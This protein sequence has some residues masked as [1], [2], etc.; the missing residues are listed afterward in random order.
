MRAVEDEYWWYAALRRHVADEVA[1]R[2]RGG[3]IL[4]SGCGTG[5][6]LAVLR[7]RFPDAELVGVD[8][9][10]HALELTAARRAGAELHRA[11]VSRLPFGDQSFGCALSI[12]VITAATVDAAA[13]VAELQ[14]VLLPGG[15]LI[16]NVAAFRFLTGAH[17]V[18]VD[19]N[20]RFTRPE[21]VALLQ[22]HEF[23]VDYATYWNASMFP[24]V[25]TV[26]WLSRSQS[27]ARSDFTRLPSVVNSVLREIAVTELRAARF[28]SLPFCTS[29]FAVA[30]RR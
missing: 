13:A 4:D 1:R 19:V 5:G 23:E 30:H 3:K 26:R 11:D 7:R 14:R 2:G 16:V 27:T 8:Q 15:T 10:E 17:D 24:A 21:L 9:S 25:A 22:S 28:C 20:R 29:V 12:D 6:T 18:A